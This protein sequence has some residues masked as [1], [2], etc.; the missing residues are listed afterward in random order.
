AP[1]P[2]GP[3]GGAAAGRWWSSQARSASGRSRPSR[4]AS[5]LSSLP[6][7]SASRAVGWRRTFPSPPLRGFCVPLSMPISAPPPRTLRRA[8][9]TA[10]SE[11]LRRTSVHWEALAPAHRLSSDRRRLG[12]G[13]P[14]PPHLHDPFRAV[15]AAA[16]HHL[17]HA[18]GHQIGR[19]GTDVIPRRAERPAY[20]RGE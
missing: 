17:K 14:E 5:V 18:L 1:P 13:K 19:H 7:S 4:G 6:G 11:P 10:F 9:S 3:R 12:G 20:L 2:S 15:V 8:A 16:R